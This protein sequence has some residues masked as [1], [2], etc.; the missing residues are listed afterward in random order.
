M[1]I[2]MDTY[3]YESKLYETNPVVKLI[4]AL[5]LLF[6]CIGS[7]SISVYILVMGIMLI[8]AVFISGIK[9]RAYLDLY[10]IP[11]IFITLSTIGV[12]LNFS[13]KTGGIIQFDLFGI[14][15][16]ITKLGIDTAIHLFLKAFG[17]VSCLYF[18]IVSTTMSDFIWSLYQM[19][20]PKLLVEIMFLIYRFIFL[21]MGRTNAIQ[22]S[23]KAR[24]GYGGMKQS[25][26]SLGSLMSSVFIIS[27]KKADDLYHSM[28]SRCYE[29]EF[30][31]IEKESY[32]FNRKCKIQMF[33]I[34]FLAVF[35]F[36]VGKLG[37]LLWAKI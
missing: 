27:F 35:V 31:L 6:V 3:G 21:L 1:N 11:I 9:W 10:R 16:S 25:F 37:E 23:Q 26:C 29:G 14:Y 12:V 8:A 5:S 22:I 20:L 28:E 24:L 2:S 17:A 33:L 34:L 30:F 19:K 32:Q 13:K 15:V 18:I 7:S 36:T 4:F